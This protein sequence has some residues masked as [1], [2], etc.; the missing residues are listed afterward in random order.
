MIQKQKP[1]FKDEQLPDIQP[2]P[3]IEELDLTKKSIRSLSTSTPRRVELSN[4]S[5][6]IMN[7]KP[8][9]RKYHR[10]RGQYHWG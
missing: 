5:E 8:R 10:Q 6:E 3:E 1:L 4:R 7:V 9:T 2:Q